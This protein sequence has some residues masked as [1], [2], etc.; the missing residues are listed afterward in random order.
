[1]PR[2]RFA[3]L[4]ILILA[5]LPAR[6]A[7]P[8][9]GKDD[10]EIVAQIEAAVENQKAP[11]GFGAALATL[12]NKPDA[13]IRARERAAWA[14]GELG[15]K[16][17]APALLTAAGHKGLLIRSAALGALARL[18]PDAAL[19]IFVN[20]AETDPILALRQR[21]TI[22]LGLYRSEKAIDPLV[23]LSSDPT[24]EIRG[25]A[26][27]A[28]AM[29]HSKKSDFSE[30]LTEMAADE[31]A[32][33]RE[34]SEHG[35]DIAKG[36]KPEV[37][38]GLTSGDSD[39]RLA[40]AVYL[41]R[42]AVEEDVKPLKTAWSGE[43]DGDV[44]AQ[45]ERAVVKTQARVKEEKARQAAERKAKAAAL[46]AQGAASTSTATSGTASKA[47]TGKKKSTTKKAPAKSP[48]K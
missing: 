39:I 19:P 18:R 17:G 14:M 47:K 10:E 31:D 36:R 42:A 33:V 3:L 25:A 44:K 40:S 9:R 37:L 48:A 28:M 43:E 11:E 45:L 46:A 20:T 41:E 27:L 2:S 5:A 16:P 22:A 21:A 23:K 13:G 7:D 4:A 30:I 34:R 12:L 32:Y 24:P 29:M 8:F 6:A 35:L 15:Y 1:M 38:Q 26:A